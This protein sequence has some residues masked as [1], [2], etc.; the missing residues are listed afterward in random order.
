MDENYVSKSSVIAY[1]LWGM[2]AALMGAA[3][4]IGV[5]WS[6]QWHYSVLLACTGCATSALAATAHIKL[7]AQRLCAVIRA[8]TGLGPGRSGSV[9][10]L[11]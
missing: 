7:Y 8:A 1:C 5:F 11:R 6:E 2:V 4:L 10:N 9:R 3:W